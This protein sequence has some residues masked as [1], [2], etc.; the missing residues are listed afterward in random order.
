MIWVAESTMKLVAA[1]P[2]KV[3]AVA[4][5]SLLPLIMT[6]VPPRVDPEDGLRLVTLGASDGGVTL[7]ARTSMAAPWMRVMMCAGRSL[8]ADACI[9]E[10]ATVP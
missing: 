5:L 10:A 2:P 8:A 9:S 6:T 4:P 7:P 3:T 1:V